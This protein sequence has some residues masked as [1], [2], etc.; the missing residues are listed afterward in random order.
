M[1]SSK[2]RSLAV[3]IGILVSTVLAVVG[4]LIMQSVTTTASDMAPR[5]VVVSKITQNSAEVL[6]STGQE[7]QGVIEYGTSPTNLNFFAP[8]STKTQEHKAD[9]TLLSPATTYYFQIR[10][11]DQKYDNAGVPWTFT[12]KSG[13]AEEDADADNTGNSANFTTSPTCNE[14]DCDKIKEK[15]FSGCD[16]Q[17][18]VK[19]IKAKEAAQ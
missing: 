9:L 14:T 7:T 6:W 5:D 17:D 1:N 4:Y 18:Y 16:T 2:S 19:C 15:F 13:T 12:T 8:E 11:A 10:V 3:F